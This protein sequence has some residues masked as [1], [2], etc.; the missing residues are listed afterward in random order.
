M[1]ESRNELQPIGLKNRIDNNLKLS[2]PKPNLS[3][4]V[5]NYP[6][7][8]PTVDSKRSHQ[9]GDLRMVKNL[10]RN[11]ERADDNQD[12]FPSSSS[13]GMASSSMRRKRE[14][15]IFANKILS[16]NNFLMSILEHSPISQFI[17]ASSP[18]TG[19]SNYSPSSSRFMRLSP[20]IQDH[21]MVSFIG[22]SC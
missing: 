3:F 22:H 20:I 12:Y 19:G 6:S 2:I 5:R 21:H 16:T 18:S 10:I 4:N 11:L 14:I 1:S 9:L 7:T 8:A 17:D 15:L 13:P